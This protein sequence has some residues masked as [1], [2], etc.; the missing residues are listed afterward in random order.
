MPVSQTALERAFTTLYPLQDLPDSS[1]LSAALEE[2]ELRSSALVC[3]V[4]DPLRLARAAAH[5]AMTLTLADEARLARAEEVE[6]IQAANLRTTFR[7]TR[8]AEL[9][10]YMGLTR[11]SALVELDLA[12]PRRVSRFAGV[13]R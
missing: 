8:A 13:A 11:D 10:T 6:S 1:V 4:P 9:E 12:C 3:T 2:I 5:W 7:Q